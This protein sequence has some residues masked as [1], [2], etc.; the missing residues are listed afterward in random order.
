MRRLFVLLTALAIG[1]L[2]GC[3]SNVG[4]CKAYDEAGVGDATEAR[5]SDSPATPAD[6]ASAP[7]DAAVLPDSPALL[8]ASQLDDAAAVDTSTT[9]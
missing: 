7:V 6:S 4:Y 2:E 3:S 1:L 8:D 5:G 9:D